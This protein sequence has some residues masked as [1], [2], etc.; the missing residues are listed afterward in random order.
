MLMYKHQGNHKT[1]TYEIYTQKRE[2]NPNIKL[3]MVIKSQRNRAKKKKQTKKN[4][5]NNPKTINKMVI[6]TYI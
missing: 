3:K 6:S 2:R 5:E 1:K 4:Y